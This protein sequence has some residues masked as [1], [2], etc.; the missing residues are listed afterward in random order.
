[1]PN[2]SEIA[3]KIV[4][5]LSAA[6]GQ[7]LPGTELATTL[8]STCGFSSAVHGKLRDFVDAYAP[9]VVR[10]GQTGKDW[11]YQLKSAAASSTLSTQGADHPPTPAPSGTRQARTLETG[12]WKAFASPNSPF[13]LVAN[14]ETGELRDLPPGSPLPGGPWKQVPPCSVEKHLEIAAAWVQTLPDPK[15]RA[16]LET[17]LKN[18]SGPASIFYETVKKLALAPQWN[19]FRTQRILAVFEEALQTMRI[20]WR[21][22]APGDRQAGVATVTRTGRTPYAAGSGPRFTPQRPREIA[23]A[24]LERMSDAE[25]RNLPI[26]LGYVLD[27]LEIR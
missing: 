13:K 25:I 21:Q 4:E 3:S 23:V 10:V 11:I 20:P 1:M 19:R 12:V 26:P 7:K 5:I 15:T 27:I 6:P 18:G 24:A 16:F 14:E 2:E 17:A 8:K 9:S 22:A